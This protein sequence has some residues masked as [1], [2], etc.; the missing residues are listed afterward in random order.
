M[1][2]VNSKGKVI[3]NFRAPF[4]QFLKNLVRF[5]WGVAVLITILYMCSE[6][7]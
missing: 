1:K 3:L 4:W 7:V 6:P 5:L 2:L